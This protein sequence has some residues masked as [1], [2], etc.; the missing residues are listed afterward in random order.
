[1]IV[2]KVAV[3]LPFCH[4][5]SLPITTACFSSEHPDWS[6]CILAEK[7]SNGTF[8]R[9]RRICIFEHQSSSCLEQLTLLL[10]K[11]TLREPWCTEI[12]ALFQLDTFGK[13]QTIP[14]SRLNYQCGISKPS[15]ALV[16]ILFSKLKTSVAT[17]L[18]NNCQAKNQA[19]SNSQTNSGSLGCLRI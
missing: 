10:L 4:N 3:V 14:F 6:G 16:V 15:L 12:K 7:W 17:K 2:Y 19:F 18:T 11:E 8:R 13:K 1:M 9:S 5:S